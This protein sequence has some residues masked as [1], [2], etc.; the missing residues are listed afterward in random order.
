MGEKDFSS[1]LPNGDFFPFWDDLTEYKEFLYVD[2]NSVDASDSNSGTKEKPF[3]TINAAAQLAKPG[4]KVIIKGG[5]YHETVKPAR[6]GD[7]EN[8]MICYEAAEGEN[9]VIKA[10]VTITKFKPSVGWNFMGFMV[11]D[12]PPKGMTVWEIDIDP[13]DF[14]G[15]NPFCSV[16]IIHDR[17]FIEYDKT[18]MTTYLNRRGMVFFDGRPLKQ[19]PLFNYMSKEDSTY[20]VESNGQKIHMRLPQDADPKDHKIEITNREQC[21]APD[22]PFLSYIHVRN[23]VCAHAATGAPVP[24]RGSISAFRGHHWII[25]GCTINWSNGVGIDCGNECWHHGLIDG[26]ILGYNIIR[27]NT[28]RNV[29][30]CGIA[31]MFSTNLLIEDNL[32]EGTGWQRMELSWEAGGIKVHD[33]NSALFRRNVITGSIGCD[34]IWMDVNNIN[35][36]LTG[37]LLIDGINSREHIFMEC[38]RDQETMIDNNIIWNVEGRFDR[39]AVPKEP[40]SSGWYKDQQLTVENGYGIY[41]EGNDRLRIVNNLIGKCYDSGF[42]AK[43]VAFRLMKRGGTARDCRFFNNL[44]YGC[45]AAAIKMPNEHNEAEGNAYAKMPWMGGYL[46]ILQPAPTMCLD[47]DSW[48]EFC[49]FDLTGCVSD[50]EIEIDSKKLEMSIDLKTELPKVK[51]DEKAKT[52]YFNKLTDGDTRIAGPIGS[53]NKGKTVINIDPRQYKK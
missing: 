12:P 4:T 16:N 5:E 26:Q 11:T 33:A 18:D 8:S 25:E 31:A 1:Q 41:A 3:K 46:R 28:I 47:L 29:G 50:I 27:G 20:W 48:R 10:S 9:V 53:I 2:G 38:T 24:Q 30:V 14:K 44:F 21:F 39:N 42:F 23:L 6:G 52:D 17:I 32:I 40:G 43:V 35:C 22:V 15:Y 36:R 37:N 13:E 45:G 7:N 19:V 49:S 34:S 51:T